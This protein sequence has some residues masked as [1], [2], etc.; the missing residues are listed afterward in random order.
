MAG[1]EN[2]RWTEMRAVGWRRAAV[3]VS[4]VLRVVVECGGGEVWQFG[5]AS[6]WRKSDPVARRLEGV[7]V[8]RPDPAV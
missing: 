3:F 7:A 8:Q 5:E 4:E 2:P 1:G 6:V